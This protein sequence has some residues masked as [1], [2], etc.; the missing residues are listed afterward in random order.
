MKGVIT[1][2]EVW[3]LDDGMGTYEVYESLE[4]AREK[5]ELIILKNYRSGQIDAEQLIECLDEL[6]ES[7]NL[8]RG[9]VVDE[10][11]WCWKIPYYTKRISNN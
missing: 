6:T 7:Y 8:E 4:D 2:K 9:F 1:M 11:V 5:A 10:V 3:I